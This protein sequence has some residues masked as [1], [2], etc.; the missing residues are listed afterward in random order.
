MRAIRGGNVPENAFFIIEGGLRRVQKTFKVAIKDLCLHNKIETGDLIRVY[1]RKLS[2]ENAIYLGETRVQHDYR[3]A[4]NIDQE[5]IEPEQRI[6]E[7]DAVSIYITKLNS[8]GVNP[9]EIIQVNKKVDSGIE[10]GQR[11][12]E[13]Q[14]IIDLKDVFKIIGVTYRDFVN[15]YIRKPGYPK[16]INAGQR[17]VLKKGQ[18]IIKDVLRKFDI[19]ENDVVVVYL[20]K[21]DALKCET[22]ETDITIGSEGRRVV[23]LLE[24]DNKVGSDYAESQS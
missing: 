18:I 16:S 24:D 20:Y 23:I 21:P 22:T 15:V 19:K 14:G 17:R 3:I 1:I 2:E 12:V 9:C 8:P 11:I 6:N 13:R 7:G 10:A 4:L 5:N